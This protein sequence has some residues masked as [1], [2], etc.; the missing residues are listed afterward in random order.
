MTLPTSPAQV[1][2]ACSAA[3][4]MQALCTNVTLNV[5][6]KSYHHSKARVRARGV[7]AP[8]ARSWALR[9]VEAD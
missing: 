6:L 4:W 2:S 1:G 7:C 5:T 8:V 9:G 3:Q